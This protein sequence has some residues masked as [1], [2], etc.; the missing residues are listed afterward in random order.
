M[1]SRAWLVANLLPETGKGLVAGQW[2]TY[3]TFALLDLAAAIMTGR[4]FIDFPVLRRGGVLFIAAEGAADIPARLQ[5]VLT[6]KYPEVQRAPFAWAEVCPRLLDRD[7][8]DVL[9][10]TA[11]AAAERCSGSS[12]CPSSFS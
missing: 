3:K 5:A 6:A 10:A 4:S 8:V 12:G 9:V 1:E 7:A 11:Q 2:G